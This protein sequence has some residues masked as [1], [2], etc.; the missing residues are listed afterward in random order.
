MLKKTKITNSTFN[1]YVKLLNMN[2]F[3]T[4]HISE[5][6]SKDTV[7]VFS[8]N[9]AYPCSIKGCN[10]PAHYSQRKIEDITFDYMQN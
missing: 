5:N 4:I 7:M 10:E 2:W 8:M 3:C 6:K 9:T 1:D